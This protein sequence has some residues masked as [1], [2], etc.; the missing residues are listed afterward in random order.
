MYVQSAF[1]EQRLDV[2]HC[3]IRAHPLATFIMSI[4]DE[5]V[6]DHM[7]LLIDSQAGEHG[8]LRG[9]MPRANEIWQSLDGE[10]DAVAVFQGPNAY[11]TP[12]W[13]PSKH[14][15]GK[16]V[17]TWNYAV[18][19]AHGR[20]RAIADAVWLRSHLEQLTDEHEARQ[21]LPWKVSDAPQEFTDRMIR[22]IVGIEMPI[23]K[24]LGK[25]KA[26]QNRPEADR[27]G[28]VAGLKSRG[29][30]ASLDMAELVVQAVEARADPRG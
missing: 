5:I 25:W 20:P 21:A 17:P 22:R 23:A 6:V 28:V 13:Y 29:D 24:I 16:A 18:V 7:P 14:E 30:D 8:V 19:H 4:G 15:H 26:S 12:S 11:V 2:L 9:H 3:H 27:L 10:L 1:E